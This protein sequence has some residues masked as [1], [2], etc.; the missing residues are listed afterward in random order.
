MV[1]IARRPLL[2]ARAA[3]DALGGEPAQALRQDVAPDRQGALDVVETRA[4]EEDLAQDERRP[5]VAEEVHRAGD[6]ARPLAE[7]GA[8]HGPILAGCTNERTRLR[9]SSSN[10][11]TAGRVDRHRG[12]QP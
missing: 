2:V 3:Q 4:A 11:L 10:E 6:R 5:P 7:R 9:V 8:T 1:L 12:D